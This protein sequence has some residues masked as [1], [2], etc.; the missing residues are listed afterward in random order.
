MKPRTPACAL[1]GLLLCAF[2]RAVEHFARLRQKL[3][4]GRSPC[5]YLDGVFLTVL[6]ILTPH[7]RLLILPSSN[8]VL[9]VRTVRKFKMCPSLL[10]FMVFRVFR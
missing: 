5:W 1:N 6:T 7:I 10:T 2:R 3:F 9:T 4:R 8:H